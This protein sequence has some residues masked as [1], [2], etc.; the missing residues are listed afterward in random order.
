MHSQLAPSK[1]E[2]KG[3]VLHGIPGSGKTQLALRYVADY[4]DTYSHILWISAASD[5]EAELSFAEAARTIMATGSILPTAK[6]DR[7]YIHACLEKHLE[8]N[9]LIVL[10]SLDS[11]TIGSRHY[12]PEGNR[13]S[14]LITSTRADTKYRYR[15]SGLELSGLDEVSA[16]NLLTS[17]AHLPSTKQS[18]LESTRGM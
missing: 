14:V 4:G 16:C 10:D 7:D 3:L 13:G 1:G 18:G 9:W 8:P 12:L 2:R 17:L 11:L 6:S 5:P 15:F